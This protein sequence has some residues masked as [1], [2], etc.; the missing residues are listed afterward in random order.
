MAETYFVSKNGASATSELYC[1]EPHQDCSTS[2]LLCPHTINSGIACLQSGDTLIVGAGA[3]DE[4]LTD[5]R[6]SYRGTCGGSSQWHELGAIQQLFALRL[7][8]APPYKTAQT[9]D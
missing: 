4:G 6:L 7:F 8:G 1:V 3:Y 2:R 9:V 5:Y